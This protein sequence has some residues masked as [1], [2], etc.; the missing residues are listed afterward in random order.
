M[1][2]QERAPGALRGL[3]PLRSLRLRPPRQCSAGRDRLVAA[4]DEHQW[5]TDP[6]RANNTTWVD[7]QLQGNGASVRVLGYG[8]A[9]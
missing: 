1:N 9:A 3:R 2:E 5:F 8:P 4:A 6:N 7:L